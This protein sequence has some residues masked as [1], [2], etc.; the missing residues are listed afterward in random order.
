MAGFR[1]GTLRMTVN[2]MPVEGLAVGQ[3]PAPART[4]P[5]FSTLTVHVRHPPRPPGRG[6]TAE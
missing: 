2:P 1:I 6:G 3:S 5:R 4:V